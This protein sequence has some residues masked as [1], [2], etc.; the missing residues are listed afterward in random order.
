MKIFYIWIGLV[1]GNYLY[2]FFDNK[3]WIEAFKISYFQGIFV[4]AIKLLNK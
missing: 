2:Q 1:I 3:N 4:L